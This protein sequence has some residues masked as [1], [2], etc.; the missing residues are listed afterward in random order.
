MAYIKLTRDGPVLASEPPDLMAVWRELVEAECKAQEIGLPPAWYNPPETAPR[1]A[2]TDVSGYDVAAER[3]G[4]MLAALD[5]V[6][7]AHAQAL[8]TAGSRTV[9]YITA[10]QDQ[11]AVLRR[12]I[13]EDR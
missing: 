4:R 1:T 12:Y 7:E 9:L 11:L 2:S 5:V 10:A 6:V 3:R 13:E 8:L